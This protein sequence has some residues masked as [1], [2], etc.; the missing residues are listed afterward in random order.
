MRSIR[1]RLE[2]IHVSIAL[3]EQH[4]QD[5]DV[6]DFTAAFNNNALLTDTISY[7][8][9]VIGEAISHLLG[10]EE[11]NTLP[12][13]IIIKNPGI[14]WKG[15][16]AIRHVL[17]HQYFRRSADKIWVAIEKELPALKKVIETELGQIAPNTPV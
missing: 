5:M 14:D 10:D 16:A 4:T 9:L 17:A 2:D 1:A 8:F 13:N 6:R 15:Y 7:R 11:T 3:I 12:A